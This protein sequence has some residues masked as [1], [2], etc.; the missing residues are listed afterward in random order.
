[1]ALNPLG[2]VAGEFYLDNSEVACIMGPVGSGKT[3]AACLR[4]ARHIM[5]E[6]PKE[7]GVRRSR[8]VV[9]RNT[10]PQ[11]RDTTIKTWLEV[12]PESQY[13]KLV[14]NPPRQVWNF[15]PRG[16]PHPIYAE[17]L[18][19]SLDDASDVANLL[20]LET[21]GFFFN[22][23]KLIA[24]E[25]IQHA[26]RRTGRAFGGGTKWHGWIADSNPWDF[27]SYH[28]QIFVI[29]NRA[30]YKFFKQPG[31]MDVDA[32]NLENLE[33]T[34]DT[35][36]LPWNDPARREQGRTYYT[37]A[38]RDYTA[39]EAEMYVHCKYG[40]SRDGKPVFYAYNDSTH[41]QATEV[42]KDLPLEIGYDCTGRNPAAIIG[43]RSR[44]GR[45]MI[46]REFVGEDVGMKEHAERCARFVKVEFPGMHVGLITGDP[47]GGAED[48]QDVDS[49]R[50]IRASFPGV[51]VL[52][53]TTNDPRTRVEACNG[54]FNRMING[55]PGI[56]INP[57]CKLLRAAA[58]SK[59]QYRK[60]K[61]SGVGAQYSDEPNKIHPWSDV[62][63]GLQ[64]LLLGGGEGRIAMG[65][66]GNDFSGAAIVP[67]NQDWNVFA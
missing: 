43:Q 39:D 49:F 57:L 5:E 38:L 45:W 55:E 19:R 42:D 27:E 15:K 10:G 33:Q 32:E 22:E 48:A 51:R 16:S 23:L 66:T 18:F 20:S 36:L 4:I 9:V 58:I 25:I 62:A 67:K 44:T 59:Y 1:M 41:C 60:L 2:Q 7:D 63:D 56:L 26:G 8:W 37:K 6:H 64:Y 34:P 21:T 13:G 14:G 47:A 29:E 11:L 52:K 3:N 24:P 50:L 61:L 46:H 53:A 65:I 31:G 35:L 17:I 54:A 28:H 40:A 30:G 12:F